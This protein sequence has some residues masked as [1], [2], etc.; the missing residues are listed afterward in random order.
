MCHLKQANYSRGFRLKFSVNLSEL[1]KQ[2]LSD[3]YVNTR[4]SLSVESQHN[5]G[6]SEKYRLNINALDV[7]ILVDEPNKSVFHSFKEAILSGRKVKK[8]NGMVY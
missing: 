8:Y 6:T 2:K 5:F 4:T 7:E 3:N 1:I